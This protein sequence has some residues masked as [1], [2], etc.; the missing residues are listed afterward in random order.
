MKLLQK[1]DENLVAVGVIVWQ[2]DCV[3]TCRKTV[4]VDYV[5][6]QRSKGMLCI[7][8]L[9]VFESIFK[10][11]EEIFESAVDMGSQFA[12]R[13]LREILTKNASPHAMNIMRDGR[14]GCLKA[15]KCILEKLRFLDP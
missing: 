3:F 9:V 7:D 15:P 1:L 2:Q 4:F 8:D 13:L 11:V 14:E 6:S 10:A 5:C 12:N